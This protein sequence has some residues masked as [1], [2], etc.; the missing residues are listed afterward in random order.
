MARSAQ[1]CAAHSVATAWFVLEELALRSSTD[2]DGTLTVQVSTRD[3]A[4]ALALNKDTVTRALARLREHKC[5]G[6]VARGG[7]A[8]AARLSVHTPGLSM[9]E[10][11]RQ[12]RTP[13]R[14]PSDESGRLQARRR[15][16]A[17][18]S[19]LSLLS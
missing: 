11:E 12:S 17:G 9:F 16:D 14:S 13:V 8:G 7:S 10:S 3:L 15:R 4:D 1:H 19:Q 18:E 2:R 6:V 5:I